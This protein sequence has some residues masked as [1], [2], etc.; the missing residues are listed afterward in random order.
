MDSVQICNALNRI[1]A[2][3]GGSLPVYLSDAAPWFGN[4]STAQESLRS[5]ASQQKSTIDRLGRMVLELGGEVQHGSFP[6]DFTGFHDLS[7]DFLLQ[8]MIRRQRS[9]IAE[10]ESIADSLPES[11][12]KSAAEEALGA[13][14][15]H[16]E[17]LRELTATPS[18]I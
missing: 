12:A 16:L 9:E 18:T 11:A 2:I 6:M 8:E 14:H 5:I 15:G 4:N 1:I 10:I 3:H 7:L 17:T 13:A